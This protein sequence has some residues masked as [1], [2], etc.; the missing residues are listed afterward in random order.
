MI[1][2]DEHV[3]SEEEEETAHD[4]EEDVANFS[5]ET[6]GAPGSASD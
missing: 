2:R 5:K 4:D 6:H 3:D 1:G